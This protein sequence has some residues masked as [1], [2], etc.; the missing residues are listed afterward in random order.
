MTLQNQEWFEVDNY[1][2]DKIKKQLILN[3]HPISI[4]YR[5]EVV[6]R[7]SISNITTQDSLIDLGYGNSFQE[8]N[9]LTQRTVQHSSRPMDN[10]EIDRHQLGIVFEID[11]DLTSI[12]RKMYTLVDWF[13]DIGGLTSSC[14]VSLKLALLLV[15]YKDL[16]WYLVSKLYKP[17]ELVADISSDSD[18]NESISD[19]ETF[20]EGGEKE[21]QG[22]KGEA[23]LRR[24]K[25][26]S[27]ARILTKQIQIDNKLD[28]KK[29]NTFKLNILEK[30]QNL[31][32]SCRKYCC[33]CCKPTK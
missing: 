29:V 25:R 14:L 28:L 10:I 9:F 27:V 23:T 19:G 16:E 26:K 18:I 17:K 22:S 20:R 11:P 5:Q 21:D 32:P 33:R 3:W 24:T 8:E 12:N 13:S 31:P 15:K 2:E 7:I 4:Q 1:D 30:V 6:N